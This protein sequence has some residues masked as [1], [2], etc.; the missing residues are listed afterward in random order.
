[1]FAKE[2]TNARFEVIQDKTTH[3]G[4]RVGIGVGRGGT[5]KVA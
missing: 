5:L 3:R 4:D 1:M 2:E